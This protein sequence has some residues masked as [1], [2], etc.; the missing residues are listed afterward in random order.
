MARRV[1]L[2]YFQAMSNAE[3]YKNLP[4][5]GHFHAIRDAGVFTPLPDDWYVIVT[6]V[7]GSKKAIEEGKYKEVNTIGAASITAVV[8]QL[9]PLEVPY[10]FGGDGASIC[11]P[12][13]AYDKVV[14]ALVGT[15][16][17]ARLA[18]NLQLRTGIIPVSELKQRGAEVLVA[19][20]RVN[21]NYTQALFS[22][23]GLVLA[24]SIIKSDEGKDYLFT[25]STLKIE[26]DFTG[27]ECR[28]QRIQQDNKRVSSIL[29]S[30]K[31]NDQQESME[32]YSEVM[33]ELS[34]IMKSGHPVTESSLR[35]SFNPRWLNNEVGPR[36]Y[37][38]SKWARM[39][40]FADLYYRNVIGF[41]LMKFNIEVNDFNWGNYK[42]QFI[43]N[44]DYRKIDD[45]LRAVLS[46]TGEETEEMIRYLDRIEKEGRIVYGVHHSDAAIVTCMV[47]QYDGLHY[48]FVD[49]DDGGYAMAAKNM[50]S[51]KS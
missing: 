28:W 19:R 46:G 43:D 21:P 24:D 40:Y 22:G 14:G 4:E 30:A 31:G 12:P 9:A 3:F 8:N 2:C 15:Q 34:R 41:F 45:M 39:R 50:L 27:L 1:H 32:I 13:E 42:K 11:I 23:G 36:T 25:S 7:Q 10:I 47:K 6:D 26:A 16:N 38:K 35:F 49:G 18:F 17:M 20:F 44:S 37:L 33:D 48:H 29:V 51:K 5:I